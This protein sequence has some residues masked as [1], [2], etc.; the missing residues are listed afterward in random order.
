METTIVIGD[1]T[2]K[3]CNDDDMFGM[4]NRRKQSSAIESIYSTGID[5][6]YC[7]SNTYS[8]LK[9][10]CTSSVSGPKLFIVDN[11]I[12]SDPKLIS[13]KICSVR[14]GT[15]ASN[16]GTIIDGESL[17]DANSV[18]F[19]DVNSFHQWLITVIGPI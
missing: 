13:T 4:W 16:T 3:V 7:S 19:R 12:V 11:R 6:V 15:G 18:N 10:R 8:I 1:K 2:Y 14:C 17:T 9:A 5:D